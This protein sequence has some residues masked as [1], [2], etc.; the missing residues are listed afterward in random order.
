[1]YVPTYIYSTCTY[2]V[3]VRVY[4][5]VE[6]GRQRDRD[7]DIESETEVGTGR[8]PGSGAVQ[9]KANSGLAHSLNTTRVDHF[10]IVCQNVDCSMSRETSLM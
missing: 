2:I 1:M 5:Y 7:R 10:L 4:I 6:R 9:T 8:M 3:G